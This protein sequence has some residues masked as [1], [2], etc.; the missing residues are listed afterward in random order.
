MN[1]VDTRRLIDRPKAESSAAVA[2]RVFEARK[3]QAERF[4]SEGISTNAEM[5]NAQ[6]E[7]FCP[8]SDDCKSLLGNIIDRLGLSA[9]AYSRIVRI[10][11]T[12]ADLSGVADIQPAHISEAAG[13]RFLDRRNFGEL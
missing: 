8:L 4:R 6:M 9:R 10:A 13:Y 11:R 5:S 12:I 2:A 1:P 3:L 7:K